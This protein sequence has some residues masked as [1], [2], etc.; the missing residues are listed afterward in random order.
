MSDK[1][2]PDDEARRG[3]SELRDSDHGHSAGASG[4]ATNRSTSEA[5]AAPRENPW[6]ALK[7]WQGKAAGLDK[8]LLF[9]IIGV[10]L[11]YL[12][13]MPLRPWMLVNAPVLQEFINGAK[14][15]VVAAGA[16]ASVGEIPLWLVVVAGFIG[17]AKFDWAFWLA[18]RRWGDGVLRLFA[19]NE[20]QLKRIESLKRIPNWALFLM[21]IVS[22]CPG[23][24]GTLVY[25]VAGWT[26]M[27]LSLFLIA[28]LLG[29]L[30][31]TLIW[32]TLGYQL[33]E[34]AVDVLKVVDKYALWLTLAI[35]VGI[36]VLTYIREYRKQKRAE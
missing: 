30:I 36:F 10:P 9:I 2:L 8:L 24:P 29:C 25:L 17:M 20:R 18:G 32:T 3:D 22:R 19:Q 27:R 21:T 4:E 26:R 7:P 6:A 33:G 16:Y 5:D 13:L 1:R 11:V 23:V 34:T 31:F 14:T 12:A 35:I 15:A 28:D